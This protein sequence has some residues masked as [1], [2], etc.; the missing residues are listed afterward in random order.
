MQQQYH[1]QEL[2]IV[3]LLCDRGKTS[4]D[5]GAADGIYTIHVVDA[6]L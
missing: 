4:I 2:H 1:E 5:I 3:P 6:F